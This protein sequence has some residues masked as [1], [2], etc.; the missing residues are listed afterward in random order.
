MKQ[1][2]VAILSVLGLE[3]A[4]GQGA[5]LT[6]S[7]APPQPGTIVRLTLATTSSD[8][9]SVIPV[10]GLLSGE[11]LHFIAAGKKSWHAIGGIPPAAPRPVSPRAFRRRA[12]GRADTI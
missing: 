4:A 11:P 8:R 10:H 7:P 5:R 6:A 2:F 9:D 1:G 3:A 12:S